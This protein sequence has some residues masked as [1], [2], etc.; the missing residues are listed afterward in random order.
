MI[1]GDKPT[2]LMLASFAIL[3]AT[4]YGLDLKTI[5]IK[6]FF[7][8]LHVNLLFLGQFLQE[9]FIELFICSAAVFAVTALLLLVLYL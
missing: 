7:R 1:F 6:L 5:K 4:L 2:P 8:Q 3:T 9:F